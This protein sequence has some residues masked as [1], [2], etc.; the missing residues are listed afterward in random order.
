[1]AVQPTCRARILCTEDH[2]DTRDLIA[3]A[4]NL[5]GY[6]VVCADTSQD[7]LNLAKAESFDLF[8]VD[9]RLPG[10][11]GTQLTK[12]LREFDVT[13]PILF[14]TGLGFQKDIAEAREAGT[15]GYL[16]KPVGT[17]DLVAEVVRLIAQARPGG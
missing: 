1:M 7:A 12:K 2:P 4:L 3:F 8:I 11:S 13:T 10:M 14:Y 15:Q 9:S 17:D 6:D 16:V 5:E